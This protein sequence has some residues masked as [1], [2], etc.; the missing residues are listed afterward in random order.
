VL[1]FAAIAG[2]VITS[3]APRQLLWSIKPHI[4][5]VLEALPL[6]IKRMAVNLANHL[7]TELKIR[8][9]IG[10]HPSPTHKFTRGAILNRRFSYINGR[11]LGN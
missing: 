3:K 1:E 4:Q 2:D 6:E 11:I 9:A 10:Y 5:W 7:Q 8:Q